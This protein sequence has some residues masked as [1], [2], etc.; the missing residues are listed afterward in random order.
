MS[1][2][3]P[4]KSSVRLSQ[5]GAFDQL[6]KKH[7]PFVCTVVNQYVGD[8]SK[9]EDIAQEIFTELWIK[10]DQISIHT[11]VPAYLRRMAATRAL[12]YIRD[13]KKYNWDDLDTLPDKPAGS[14]FQSPEAIQRLEEEELQK[15]LQIAIEMLPEKCRI[16]FMLSRYDELS[17]AEIA[18]NLSISVKTV[19]NQIGKAL[20]YL[21][22]SLSIGDKIDKSV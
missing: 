5:L 8:K 18:Q 14:S 22:M 21:R 16:I 10:R 15:S 13:T 20:K 6:F 7:Y 19:E 4:E 12:N 2:K 9:V 17:Y 3:E 1:I 11:S